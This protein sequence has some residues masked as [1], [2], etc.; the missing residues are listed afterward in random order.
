[1]KKLLSLVICKRV[2]HGQIREAREIPVCGPEHAHAVKETKCRN[3]CIVHKRTLQKGGSGYPLEC[4]DI[5]FAFGEESAR[6]AGKES[7]NSIQRDVNGCGLPKNARVRDDRK[8]FMNTRPGNA[9]GLLSRDRFRQRQ[10][11]VVMERHLR[12]MRVHQYIG[13]DGDHA[14]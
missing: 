2:S 6:H 13:V 7:P 14:P 9:E 5:T 10:A 8:K 1:M 12:S 3:P 4:I 11:S